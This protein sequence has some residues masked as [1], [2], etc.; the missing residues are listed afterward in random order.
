VRKLAVIVLI[1]L[2][3]LAFLPLGMGMAMGTCPDGGGLL[4]PTGVATCLALLAGLLLF[5]LAVLASV[6][7][8]TT[9]V[10]SSLLAWTLDRPP[11]R[12]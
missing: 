10:K 4:C 2:F 5:S 11:K 6:R 8:E 3:L 7:V 9:H 12:A 1:I